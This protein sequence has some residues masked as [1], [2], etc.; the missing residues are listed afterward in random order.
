MAQA[1]GYYSNTGDLGDSNRGQQGKWSS[2]GY[3]LKQ[4]PIQFS[5][6]WNMGMRE[7][8]KTRRLVPAAGRVKLTSTEADKIVS[9][10]GLEHWGSIQSMLRLRYLLHIEK[11]CGANS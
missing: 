9:G 8:G 7:R 3:I 4:K 11:G 5:D 2:S 10:E 6:R 1:G